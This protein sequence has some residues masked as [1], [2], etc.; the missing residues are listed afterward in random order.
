MPSELDRRLDAIMDALTAPGGPLETVPF[1]RD[2][3]TLSAFK[4]APASLPDLFAHFCAQHGDAPFLVDGDV[5]LSFAQ[6]HAIARRVACGLV[7]RH[8]VRKGD[9][10]G[11][12]ARNSANWIIVWMAILMAGGCATLLNGWW[13]GE[14]LADG[15][16][17][18]GCM[19]VLADPQRAARLDGHE[20]GAWIVAFD[21]GAPE[22]GLAPLLPSDDGDECPLP[23]LCA[24]DLAT[25]LFT[26]GSTGTCKGAVSDQRGAIHG[27]LSYAAQNLMIFTLLGQDGQAPAGQ[28]STLVNLPLFHVT[29]EVAV[30]LLSFII[31]R[32]LVLMP[33]WDAHEAMRLIEAERITY[34]VGV[35]LMSYEIA[36]HPERDRF[37]LSSCKFF[38]AGGAPRPVDHVNRLRTALPHAYPLLGYGLT[39]TNAAGC[40]N[41]NQNYLAKPGSTG[42]A[43]R[44]LMEI[45]AFDA[46]GKALPHGQTGEIAIRSLANFRG[47]WD[48]PQATTEAFLPDG[49]F[50][51]GDLGYLDEDGYLFIV[52]RKKDVVLR[53]GENIACIEV[54]HA[55]YAH[56][57][58][59]EASVF[60]LPDARLGEVPVAVYQPKPGHDVVEEDLRGFVAEQLA[61]YKVPV[62]IWR[63]NASLPRLGT[64][65][66]DKRA[67][68][69][70]YAI[71]WS[72]A[73]PQT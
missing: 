50:L 17:L 47:Y 41:Y 72:G 21:H 46:T 57:G 24:D 14:E 53:G 60:G 67:L 32:K 52:D 5:R 66:V 68:K 20:C 54:E 39:E 1:T 30:L 18:T 13:T 25:I 36:T 43:S 55:L 62:R 58:V 73:T 8:G 15:V 6:T 48:N 56:P 59:A 70:R 35:P 51:T 12:A 27:A 44:P 64:E 61:A 10:I 11:L 38:A 28:P 33:R 49:W 22:A 63:E 9:R 42:P 19:M 3:V 69:A 7:A 23:V 40:G 4:A 65:K 45:A 16:A 29:G 34:F 37:D 2:G 26:S 31:G 71:D